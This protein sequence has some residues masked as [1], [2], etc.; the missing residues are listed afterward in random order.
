MKRVF[1]APPLLVT[2]LMSLLAAVI[3]SPS[4]ADSLILVVEAAR[5]TT[6]GFRAQNLPELGRRA[7]T[8]PEG[9]ITLPDS[10]DWLE[11][12]ADGLAFRLDGEALVG[13]GSAGRFSGR[14][15]S[16][17]VDTP[18][19]L[20]DGRVVACLAAGRIEVAADR[21]VY[22][23]KGHR[24]DQ[25]GDLLLLGGIILAT[26]VLLRAARRRTRPA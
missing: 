19:Y 9:V 2:L 21:I 5:D 15:G 13:V 20:T 16:Y 11:H 4:R 12:E 14:I 24:R 17:E 10:M 3:P 25:R 18:L 7:L 22:R 1:Q 6:R 26:A 23:A 8:W